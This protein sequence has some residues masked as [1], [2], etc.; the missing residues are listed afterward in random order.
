MLVESKVDNSKWLWIN[1]P[2][3]ASTLIGNALFNHENSEGRQDHYTYTENVEMHGKY[4]GFT[5]VRNPITRFISG[6]NHVFSHCS[7]KM[8]I[9]FPENPPNT[10]QVIKFLKEIVDLSKSIDNF[11]YKTY[12]NGSDLLWL[13]LVKSLQKNFINNKIIMDPE[14][15]VMWS[16]ILP[17]YLYLDKMEVR[18]YIFRYEELSTCTQF[19]ENRLGCKVDTSLRPRSFEYVL[20]NVDF[21]NTEIQ[22]LL[23]AYYEEDFKQLNY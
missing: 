11:H 3:T 10:N 15:C 14:N 8:C 22:K 16:F 13:E 19:I 17:Q 2:K 1:I 9:T 12:Y 6:L 4:T 23:H 20:Q 21:N 18:D 7:C 5:V